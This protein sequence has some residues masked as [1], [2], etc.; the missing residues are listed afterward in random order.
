M[1][2]L[3]DKVL[4][5]RRSNELDLDQW[6]TDLDIGEH[7]SKVMT[8]CAETKVKKNVVCTGDN[9]FIVNSYHSTRKQPITY[10]TASLYLLILH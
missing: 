6:V 3:F 7:L 1:A 9:V 8:G 4:S 5:G 2:S 10:D